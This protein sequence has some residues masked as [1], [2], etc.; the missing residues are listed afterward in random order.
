[1]MAVGVV[2]FFLKLAT[3]YEKKYFLQYELKLELESALKL[4]LH[5][6]NAR[7]VLGRNEGSHY[8]FKFFSYRVEISHKKNG[9]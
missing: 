4:A 6:Q 5:F 1:M 8:D 7:R 2:D 9:R 3:L